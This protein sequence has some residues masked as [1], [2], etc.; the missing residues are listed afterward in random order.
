M[1]Q[2]KCFSRFILL[3]DQIS[4]Y[5]ILGNMGIATTCLLGC[6]IINFEINLSFLMKCLTT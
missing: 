2:E 3:T 5:E 4:L 6:D 1:I